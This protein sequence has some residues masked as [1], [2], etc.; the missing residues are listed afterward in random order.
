ML[1]QNI[2]TLTNAGKRNHKSIYKLG[3]PT[4]WNTNSYTFS[5]ARLIIMLSDN[6]LKMKEGETIETILQRLSVHRDVVRTAQDH[7][8]MISVLDLM[9]IYCKVSR[10]KAASIWKGSQNKDGKIIRKGLDVYVRNRNKIYSG[11]P[12]QM[13]NGKQFDFVTPET[14]LTYLFKPLAEW[15]KKQLEKKGLA[16]SFRR[17]DVVKTED[18]DNTDADADYV[19][20]DTVNRNDDDITANTNTI[21]VN[22][23]DFMDVSEY[24]YDAVESDAV[25]IERAKA[26][27]QR[28]RRLC[29]EAKAKTAAA[30][31][32]REIFTYRS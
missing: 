8:D 11:L 5:Q 17:N 9:Q 26:M 29:E 6:L 2:F 16:K 20:A 13:N 21:H 4:I 32:L 3:V 10:D 31:T 12:K 24:N 7:P 19:D 23:N 22:D 28:D 15:E 27:Q 18:I 1:F 25:K 30:E 14:F